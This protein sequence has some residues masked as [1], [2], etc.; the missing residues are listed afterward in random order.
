[1]KKKFP[2]S[3]T[4]WPYIYFLIAFIENEKMS[5]VFMNIYCILTIV[6]YISNI[7]YACRMTGMESHNQLAFWDMFIKLVHLP[8]YLLTVFLSV[9]LLMSMVVPALIFVGPMFVIFLMI[10]DF[11]LMAT[12]SIYGINALL[13]ARKKNAISTKFMIVQGILHF[14]FILDVISAVILF[15]KLKKQRKQ[16]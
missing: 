2:I 6:V 16:G 9:V 11:C 14:I 13:K 5:S 10:I 8:F 4:V 1:M 15:V 7:I 12:S 3:L